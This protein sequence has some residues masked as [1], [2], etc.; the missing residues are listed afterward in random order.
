MTPPDSDDRSFI[1][2]PVADSFT[3]L[4]HLA[5]FPPETGS[6]DL[7]LLSDSR[8][9][10]NVDL[11]F[12][13]SDEDLPILSQEL[14]GTRSWTID[15][16]Y[17]VRLAGGRT[18]WDAHIVTREGVLFKDLSVQAGRHIDPPFLTRM[19]DGSMRASIHAME[20]EYHDC[21]GA[22]LFPSG[23]CGYNHSHW[24]AHALP[25][26]DFFRQAK[27]E[28]DVYVVLP[29]IAPYQRDTLHALGIEDSRILVRH[30]PQ[31]F[32]FRELYAAYTC[33][34]FSPDTWVY[35]EIAARIYDG[36]KGPERIYI[37]R[38]DARNIR[39][40]LNEDRNIEVARRHG[41]EIVIPSELAF[42]EEL[43]IFRNARV[44]AGPVGA[45]LYN[46]LFTRPGALIIAL[47]DPAYVMNWPMQ[48]A[49]VRK[50]SIGYLLGNSF[51]SYEEC[52]AGSHNSWVL[53]PAAFE[54]I[55]KEYL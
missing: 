39:R 31:P 38:K 10:E 4:P 24:L 5:S 40:F 16:A 8:T 35:D 23:A 15:P 48:V 18:Y 34:D 43:R 27:V 41:F 44:I 19:P 2:V 52:Y 7:V 25:K 3:A 28:P 9:Y 11:M 32:A 49:A 13:H 17:C 54:K 1:D 29:T 30:D 33:N 37:S 12:V 45:G 36:K 53:D 51:L 14:L 6:E 46:A 55:L 42:E 50:H 22:I 21:S 20:P 47:S 26:L